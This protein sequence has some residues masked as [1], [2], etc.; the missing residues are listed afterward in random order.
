MSVRCERANNVYFDLWNR[1]VFMKKDPSRYAY[2]SIDRYDETHRYDTIAEFEF[3]FFNVSLHVASTEKHGRRRSRF[4]SCL[5]IVN[6]VERSAQV[7]RTVTRP[8]RCSK[9][10]PRNT[11]NRLRSSRESRPSRRDGSAASR[12]R[13][14]IYVNEFS[15]KQRPFRRTKT[16]RFAFPCPYC[17]ARVERRVRNVKRTRRQRKSN[18]RRTRNN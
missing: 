13:R 12:I 17:P 9:V 16:V 5:K 11:E 14:G 10:S 3:D 6:R 7:T 4:Y 1:K 8:K 15:I 2:R 18:N